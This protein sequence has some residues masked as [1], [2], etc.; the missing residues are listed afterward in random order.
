MDGS[1]TA[2]G[3]GCTSLRFEA[4]EDLKVDCAATGAAPA[5]ETEESVPMVG[6][7]GD[8]APP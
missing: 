6:L 2:F 1:M 4:T 5:A 7:V 8:G 3:V